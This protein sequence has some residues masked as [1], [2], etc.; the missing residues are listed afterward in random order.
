MTGRVKG[1][2]FTSLRSKEKAV[3]SGIRLLLKVKVAVNLPDWIFPAFG[4]VRSVRQ[5]LSTA[6]ATPVNT[7]P[8]PTQVTEV[9]A[10]PSPYQMS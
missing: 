10:V 5:M 6:H 1:A 3:P 8:S 7:L 4:S 2:F 9:E